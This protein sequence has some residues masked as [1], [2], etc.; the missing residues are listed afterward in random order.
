[1]PSW[2]PSPVTG[3]AT[4]CSPP[5]PMPHCSDES[6]SA[7]PTEPPDGY[8]PERRPGPQTPV[9]F[10]RLPARIGRLASREGA[11]A[12]HPSGQPAADNGGSVPRATTAE[13]V[14]FRAAAG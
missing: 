8:E 5:R 13:D 7:P 11:L 1:M 4:P 12:S 9:E 10:G 2:S 14:A 6:S 3:G